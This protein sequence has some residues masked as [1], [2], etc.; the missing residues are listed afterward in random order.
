MR[1]KKIKSQMLAQR[2]VL[3]NCCITLVML[4]ERLI[5]EFTKS[6]ARNVDETKIDRYRYRSTVSKYST[7]LDKKAFCVPFANV[8][9]WKFRAKQSR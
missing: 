6:K 1:E 9:R 4:E 5:L 7:L 8:Q 3:N 2:T